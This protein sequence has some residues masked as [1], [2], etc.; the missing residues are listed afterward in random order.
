M[1]KG[2]V[3]VREKAELLRKRIAEVEGGP[4]IL[5]RAEEEFERRWEEEPVFRFI[6]CR[7]S[8]VDFGITKSCDKDIMRDVW[9]LTHLP[10]KKE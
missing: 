2:E 7:T 9:L 3:E 10:P 5:K 6:L 8:V 1:P 4:E